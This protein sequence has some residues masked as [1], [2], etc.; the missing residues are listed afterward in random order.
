M[1]R[2]D[3]ALHKK[4]YVMGRKENQYVRRTQKDYSTSFK[5]LVVSEIELGELTALAAQRRLVFKE[6]ILLLLG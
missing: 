2:P 5:L 6:V 3:I 1:F 4:G